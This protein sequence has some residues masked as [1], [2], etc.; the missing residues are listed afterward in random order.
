VARLKHESTLLVSVCT[1]APQH[2]LATEPNG[3]AGAAPRRPAPGNRARATR[4][5]RSRRAPTVAG[6]WAICGRHSHARVNTRSLLSQLSARGVMSDES[7][8][9]IR[10]WRQVEMASLMQTYARRA[11]TLTGSLQRT[12][13]YWRSLIGRDQHDRLL[14]AVEGPDRL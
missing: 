5:A 1:S 2:F 12:E 8:T 11:A 7:T 3:T 9:T 4:A 10:P 14:V 6:G 13:A